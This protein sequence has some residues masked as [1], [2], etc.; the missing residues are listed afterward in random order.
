MEK[1][2]V[3]ELDRISTMD[4]IVDVLNERQSRVTDPYSPFK[5]KIIKSK[6]EILELKKQ[7]S[8]AADLN[9]WSL[10]KGESNS[11]VYVGDTVFATISDHDLTRNKSYK[12]TNIVSL[13][14]I[15]IVNDRG[16]N[17]IYTGEYFRK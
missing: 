4:F 5:Q 17:E 12:I 16:N 6:A 8:K 1:W 15:M 9:Y 10:K 2:T 14:E 3:Q 7:K 11:L 13:S